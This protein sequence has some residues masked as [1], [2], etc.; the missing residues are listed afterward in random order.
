MAHEF[1]ATARADMRPVYEGSMHK[2]QASFA[3]RAAVNSSQ[4]L[5][6]YEFILIIVDD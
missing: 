1:G 5:T 3:F 2:L 4:P 6:V